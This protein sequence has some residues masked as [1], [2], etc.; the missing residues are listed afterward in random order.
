MAI[1]AGGAEGEP[2]MDMNTTPLIDVMLVLLIMFIITIPIQTHAVKV[3]LPIN[4]PN[5]VKPP[6]D[7]QK[8]K[9]VITPDGQTLWNGESVDEPR[10]QQYLVQTTQLDPEPELHFPA[11]PRGA[12]RKG[13]Q[14]PGDHQA[15]AGVQARLHRQRTVSQRVLSRCGRIETSRAVPRGRLPCLR[16][17]SF[18]RGRSGN[19][20]PPPTA[21]RPC[22]GVDPATRTGLPVRTSKPPPVSRLPM[23]RAI[24]A[25]PAAQGPRDERAACRSSSAVLQLRPMAQ[26][27]RRSFT[28]STASRT[29]ATS[30]WGSDMLRTRSRKDVRSVSTFS[31]F[32][33]GKQPSV[34]T[35]STFAATK[36]AVASQH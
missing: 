8:N 28:P 22:A 24:E 12:L 31:T 1:S 19:L 27:N 17:G 14:G 18:Q 33:V 13:R 4:D 6:I 7:P 5:Q 32:A 21:S 3:D 23:R 36:T 11:R 20:A 34:S 35:F 10:L 25:A 16:A 15:V 9:I 26:R 29:P 2:M 30:A